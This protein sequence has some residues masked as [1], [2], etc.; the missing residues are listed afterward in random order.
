MSK[1]WRA[2]VTITRDVLIDAELDLDNEV[3]DIKAFRE[4]EKSPDGIRE[5]TRHFIG[6]VHHGRDSVGLPP[7]LSCFDLPSNADLEIAE[8]CL[9]ENGKVLTKW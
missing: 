2:V 1:Q 7:K 5:L 4:W 9:M 3:E 8:I 6:L